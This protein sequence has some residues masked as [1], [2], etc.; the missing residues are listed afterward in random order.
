MGW[1]TGLRGEKL[2]RAVV[3]KGDISEEFCENFA[4]H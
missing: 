1:F 4:K 2:R 3:A